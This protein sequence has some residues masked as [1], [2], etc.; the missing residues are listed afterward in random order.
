M[1]A[2]QET[3]V[4]EAREAPVQEM[5]GANGASL[6]ATSVEVDGAGPH[7]SDDT[8]GSLRDLVM[9]GAD[10]DVPRSAAL[11]NAAPAPGH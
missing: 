10:I 5:L 6:G 7:P 8:R 3:L 1:V 11:G 9:R 2:L 4:P